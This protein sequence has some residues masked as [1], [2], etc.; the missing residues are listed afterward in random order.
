MG[1]GGAGS[2]AQLGN[3]LIN[4]SVGYA[5][6]A[7]SASDDWDR[8]KNSITRG[9]QYKM[10]G[11]KN[12][13]LNPI[14]AV[15]GGL[16]VGAPGLPK[17][18]S[19]RTGGS[20]GNPALERAQTLNLSANT[21]KQ[22]SEGRTAQATADIAEADSR[23]RL[24]P[25]GLAAYGRQKAS[26]AEPKTI[27]QMGSKFLTNAL[28]QWKNRRKGTAESPWLRRLDTNPRRSNHVPQ[29]EDPSGRN[30]GRK[31]KARDMRK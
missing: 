2:L 19:T 13:G 24:S 30:W 8:Y 18:G 27:P 15:Q 5:I 14:M 29:F 31:L 6:S 25:E 7:K 22:V 21:A 4:Q 10:E 26:D 3:D 17:T 20:A 16:G 28:D 23:Y 12:A 11:L 9:F 1:F